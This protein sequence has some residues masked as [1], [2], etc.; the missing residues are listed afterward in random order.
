MCKCAWRVGVQAHA[1]GCMAVV[2]NRFI[3]PFSQARSA[4]PGSCPDQ[5]LFHSHQQFL[6]WDNDHH[7]R[8][9]HHNPQAHVRAGAQQQPFLPRPSTGGWAWYKAQIHTALAEGSSLPHQRSP[10][11]TL[12]RKCLLGSRG[13]ARTCCFGR[14]Q[15]INCIL[16][17]EH[18]RGVSAAQAP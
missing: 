14:Q 15:P 3:Q 17:N 13:A 9:R 12:H 18:T 16:Y 1:R 8:H 2:A 6:L 4:K 11:C 10:Q 7:H 5:A